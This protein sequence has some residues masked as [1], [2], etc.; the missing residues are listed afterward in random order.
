VRRMLLTAAVAAVLMTSMLMAQIP[1]PTIVK[2]SPALDA[3]IADNATFEKLGE[4]FKWT[5]GPVWDKKGGFLLFSDI[6]NN[7]I[8]KWVPG[9]PIA[10]FLKPS[11]YHGT[12]PFTGPEP[13]SNGL[14]FDAQGRLVACQHG[15]RQ[16]A[17][18][19]NGAWT[20]LA[21]K[22]E[23]KRLNSPNDLVFHSSGALYFTD[24]PYGLPKRWDDPAKELPF[25]GIY[26]RGT[27]GTVTLL[28]RELNAPNGLA[29][30]PD[31]KT[32]YVAQSDPEKA[33]WMAYPVNA[34]GTLGA[35]KVLKDATAEFKAKKPGLPDGLKVDTKGNIWAT[36]PGGVWVIAPD[37]T[38]LGTISTGVPTANVAWGDDGSTLYITANTA[39]FRVRTKATGKLP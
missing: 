1:T 38:H 26:R 23:G 31:E 25:Q 20:P 19:E 32:L 3:L 36:G 9:Q 6:P 30:S 13:G 4:G 10:T 29:F 11:G 35:G 18:Y 7:V 21:D 33:I 28:N 37:G 24:P 39:V 17:R 5:E 14:T 12:A 27:D 2:L 8:N 22:Y 34:D 16:V 15:N